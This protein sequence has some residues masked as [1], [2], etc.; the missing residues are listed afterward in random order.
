[1]LKRAQYML[2]FRGHF[3]LALSKP[4][5]IYSFGSLGSARGP[6]GSSQ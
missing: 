6:R 2:L 4:I 1:M 5:H 3:L